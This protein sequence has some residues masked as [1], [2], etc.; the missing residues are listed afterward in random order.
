MP[1]NFNTA[2]LPPL[3]VL[4]LPPSDYDPVYFMT[5]IQNLTFTIQQ[6]T[7]PGLVTA[8]GLVLYSNKQGLGET[9]SRTPSVLFNTTDSNTTTTVLLNYLPTGNGAPPAGLLANQ[10]WVDTSGGPGMGI[11]RINTL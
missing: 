1:I 5:L 2:P 3:A 4:P 7:N 8:S 11:I 10:V 9:P 6:L